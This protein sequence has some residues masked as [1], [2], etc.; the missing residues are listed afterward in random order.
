MLAIIVTRKPL[1]MLLASLLTLSTAVTLD[2]RQK[3]SNASEIRL[4]SWK[5]EYDE[6]GGL[7]GKTRHLT[8][9]DDGKVS[10]QG[11]GSMQPWH[12]S[13]SA[14]ASQLAD[15]KAI[16]KGMKLSG[17]PKPLP[18]KKGEPISDMLETTLEITYGGQKYPIHLAPE[19]LMSILESVL[20]EGQERAEDEKWT[21]AGPFK[22]G[23]VWTVRAEVRDSN[24]MWHGEEWIGTWIRQGQSKIFD[25]VWRNNKTNEEIRDT[26]EVE[27]AERGSVALHRTGAK[28]H[29][30]G[31]Y[32]SDRQ[33][34]VIGTIRPSANCSWR[35]KIDY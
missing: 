10:A 30:H 20:N 8:I 34:E 31:Y 18:R 2:A 11:G 21:K 3:T 32:T 16:L 29:Y 26:V 13:F 33:D 15:I 17:P 24:S 1:L 23:R 6:A 9:T 35:A 22:L 4:K 19:N 27:S 25:A 12:I 5:I 28:L 7:A 14:A